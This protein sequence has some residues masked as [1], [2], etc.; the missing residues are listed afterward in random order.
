LDDVL[1]KILQ[2]KKARVEHLKQVTPLSEELV[3]RN[4]PGKSVP[5]R[6][7][8]DALSRTDR[9]NFI[10]EIK[11]ASPSRGVLCEQFDP[12][13]IGIGYESNGAA[14]ISVLTEENYFQGSLD[15]LRR[16]RQSCSPPILRKDFIFDIYQLYEAAAAGADAVLLI[17]AM[18]DPALL[19]ELHKA[20]QRIGLDVLVEVHT[21]QEL[22]GALGCEARIIGINNRDLKSLKVDLQTTLQLAPH[23]P[24]SVVLVSESGIN[25][26]DD[27]RILRDSGCDA[28]LI[29]ELFMKSAHPGKALREL[30]IRSFDLTANSWGLHAENSIGH[31]PRRSV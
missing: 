5:T 11:K 25:T 27:V 20:A 23:V 24:D 29:G 3:S 12:V 31:G 7:F 8:L 21:A 18:L 9:L 15:H 30:I 2:E 10:A 6:S 28:F 13:E 22:K 14:A 19:L 1:T 26:A 4:L 16:V 17:V